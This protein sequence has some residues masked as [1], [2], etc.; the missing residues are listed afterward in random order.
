MV[1]SKCTV[2]FAD[3]RSAPLCSA[4]C[5]PSSQDK[6]DRRLLKECQE[7]PGPRISQGH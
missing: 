4:T 7:E 5:I 3:P 6:V 2:V 1:P